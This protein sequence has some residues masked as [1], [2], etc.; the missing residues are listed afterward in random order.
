MIETILG[1][2]TDSKEK[3]IC[4]QTNCVSTGPGGGLART[5]FNE[6][7]WSD[8][9]KSRTVRDKFGSIVVCGNGKEERY[10][11]NM[12]AQYYP[13][14]PTFENDLEPDR[15]EAFQKCLNKIKM[16]PDLES[17]AFPA[18]IGCAIA[19]GDWEEF[20]KMLEE[21]EKEVSKNGVIV[22]IYDYEGK[23]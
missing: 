19:G 23:Y 8:I 11:I 7:P 15:A 4:H 14:A 1:S 3:Y 12:N 20:Y 2:I 13:G 21:F 22:K 10:V 18:K 6:Y 16:I 17:I 9:Y 5:I